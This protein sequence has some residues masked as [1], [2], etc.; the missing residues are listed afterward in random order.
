MKELI[1][2]DLL[3]LVCGWK[4]KI[5]HIK[6]LKAVYLLIGTKNKNKIE[7]NRNGKYK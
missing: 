6:R 5:T 4:H 2:L 3:L 1:F 7:T